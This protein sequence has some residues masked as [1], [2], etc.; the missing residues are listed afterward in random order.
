MIVVQQATFCLPTKGDEN[1]AGIELTFVV[2]EDG[3]QEIIFSDDNGVVVMTLSI[4]EMERMLEA[5]A[6]MIRNVKGFV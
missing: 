5:V 2:G 3:E 6:E 1:P 4:G